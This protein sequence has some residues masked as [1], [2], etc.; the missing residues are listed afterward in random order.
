VKHKLNVF[1]SCTARIIYH[2]LLRFYIPKEKCTFSGHVGSLLLCVTFASVSSSADA[3]LPSEKNRG[4][5]PRTALALAGSRPVGG[6]SSLLAKYVHTKSQQGM[7]RLSSN[8][9]PPP[10]PL[11]Q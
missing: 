9:P 11:I 4:F 8:E 1:P 10:Y 2:V 5:S 3:R 6:A 7:S